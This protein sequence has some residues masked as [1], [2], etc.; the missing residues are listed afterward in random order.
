MSILKISKVALK[1]IWAKPSWIQALE[2]V[3][4]E[5]EPAKLIV[6]HSGGVQYLEVNRNEIEGSHQTLQ[7]AIK[8]F[9]LGLASIFVLL[10]IY[11]AYVNF[12]V[13]HLDQSLADKKA[14]LVTLN[15]AISSSQTI[16][17]NS[18]KLALEQER[19]VH[20]VQLRKLLKDMHRKEDVFNEYVAATSVLMKTDV[21]NFKTRLS[22]VGL[23]P[24][25]IVRTRKSGANLCEL[26]D[27]IKVLDATNQFVDKEILNLYAERNRL[28]TIYSALPK[29]LPLEGSK[30]TST[31]GSRDH[32][33]LNDSRQHAGVDFT[34]PDRRVRASGDGTVKSAEY[35]NGY[36]LTIVI[37]HGHGLETVYA[38]LSEVK[39]KAGQTVTAADA[40]GTTGNTG[41][42]TGTHLHFETRFN[43]RP[44][45]PLKLLAE[46]N[47][48]R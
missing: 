27:R 39:V 37:D 7:K 22:G 15:E 16:I 48:V 47:N 1:R 19:Q 5:S 31:F 24:S 42:S 28:S 11:I 12:R 46:A 43:G 34:S 30:T 6:T 25:L 10:V 4:P 20:V 35:K 18:I 26:P 40:I 3:L 33:I 21:S 29:M 13:W 2:Q 17:D 41:I 8:Y 45:D 14:E 32:P 38:H 36:G 44:V 23:D 9:C